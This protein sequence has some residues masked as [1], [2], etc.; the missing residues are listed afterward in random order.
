LVTDERPSAS[1]F[2]VNLFVGQRLEHCVMGIRKLK[3]LIQLLAIASLLS[4]AMA[5]ATSISGTVTNGTNGKPSAG[6]NVALI[7]VQAGMSE[8]GSTTTDAHGRY[9]ID[10]P[11]SGVYLV[12][13]NHQG[14]TYFIAA[15]QSGGSG[16]VTVY[17]VAAKVNGVAIDADMVLAEA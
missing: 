10:A 4:C 5:R 17:D 14:G 11:G 13:V 7:D 15:P 9:S 16:D 3:V 8:A 6:D 2:V 1:L 12:R